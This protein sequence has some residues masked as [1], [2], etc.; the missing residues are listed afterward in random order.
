MPTRIRTTRKTI[1]IPSARTTV[2]IKRT[3]RVTTK[4]R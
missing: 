3:V 4:R 1:R 2:R